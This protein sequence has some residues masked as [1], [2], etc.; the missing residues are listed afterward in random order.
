MTSFLFHCLVFPMW[1]IFHYEFQQAC[2]LLCHVCCLPFIVSSFSWNAFFPPGQ[3]EKDTR[4]PRGRIQQMQNWHLKKICMK[5][6]WKTKYSQRRLH[7]LS[8]RW[9]LGPLWF[10]FVCKRHNSF[11]YMYAYEGVLCTWVIVSTWVKVH[12]SV[13]PCRPTKDF[14]CLFHHLF[15]WYRAC[16]WPRKGTGGQEASQSAEVT[17]IGLFLL[18]L[19]THVFRLSNQCWFSL[20]IPAAFWDEFL[21][22]SDFRL[23]TQHS[24]YFKAEIKWAEACY[25]LHQ[26]SLLEFMCYCSQRITAR[27]EESLP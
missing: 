21:E 16:H 1:V 2:S 11:V 3:I 19:G 17:P 26:L 8:F 14:R 5:E 9:N 25:T 12:V 13:C 20:S 22:E 15:H 4:T 18:V 7:P 24:E 23:S 27:W 10:H 6:H